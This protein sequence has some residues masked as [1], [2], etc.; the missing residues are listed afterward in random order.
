MGFGYSDGVLTEHHRL[1][2]VFYLAR[3]LE[4]VRGPKL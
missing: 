1:G 4:K 2:L 3:R